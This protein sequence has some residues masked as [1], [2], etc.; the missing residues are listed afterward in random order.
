MRYFHLVRKED[1]SGVSG[2][3]KVAEGIEF[4]DGQVV[5]SWYGV[6]HTI[7]VLPSIDTLLA[8]HGHDG[9]TVVDDIIEA[10]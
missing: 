3:G 1:V 7:E 9:R 5:L 2:T 6:H 8:I 10:D 4:H